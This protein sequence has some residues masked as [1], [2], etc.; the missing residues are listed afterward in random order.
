MI[1]V[2]SPDFSLEMNYHAPVAGVDEA[3]RGPLA[4]PVVA[5]AVILNKDNIPE[6]IDDSKKLTARIREKLYHEICLHS[7]VGVGISEVFEIDKINILEATKLAMI[8][9]I[10]ALSQPPKFILVDGNQLPPNLPAPALPVIKGD[11]ISISI[12]AASIIAKVT[13]DRIMQNLSREYPIYGW[14]KNAGYGTKKHLEALILH[15]TSPH[16]RISFEPVRKAGRK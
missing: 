2:P 1:T 6:G 15:G 3:G 7:I 4:G 12:A 8:R 14:E 13:R 10:S 11:S 5:S 9:A 16:H